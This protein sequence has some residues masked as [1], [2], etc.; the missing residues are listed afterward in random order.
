MTVVQS[1]HPQQSLPVPTTEITW[2][3]TVANIYLSLGCEISLV[4]RRVVSTVRRLLARASVYHHSVSRQPKEREERS[5]L[6]S[7]AG[8]A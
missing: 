5:K 8:A 1:H 4:L 3:Y 6:T 7:G 2:P